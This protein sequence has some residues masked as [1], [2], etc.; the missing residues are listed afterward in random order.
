MRRNKSFKNIQTLFE[1]TQQADE[2]DMAVMLR[3]QTGNLRQL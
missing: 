3:E 1:E 2:L